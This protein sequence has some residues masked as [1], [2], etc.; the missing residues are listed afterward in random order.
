MKVSNQGRK[1]IQS[2]EG[3]RL[4]AYKDSAGIPTIGW[5]NTFYEDGSNV[6]MGDKITKDRAVS[7]FPLILDKFENGVTKMVKVP[8]NQ[9]QFDSLVS[10]AY[11]IGLNGFKKS[12]VLKL[13]NDNPQNPDIESAFLRWVTAGGK[14]LKGLVNRRQ[15]EALNYF[16]KAMTTAKETAIENPLTGTII[17]FSGIGFIYYLWRSK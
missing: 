3:L 16:G 11:N 13:V 2:L 4:Q 17:L 15:K 6:K 7:L 1:M 14:K 9:A 12:Q 8:V 5:G 10:L